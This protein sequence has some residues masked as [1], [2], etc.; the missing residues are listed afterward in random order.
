MNLAKA[1]ESRFLEALE[2]LGTVTITSKEATS[3][4]D[5]LG[6]NYGK[7][8]QMLS[9]LE[10]M[11]KLV[12]L[13]HGLYMTMQ[14]YR[15]LT[16]ILQA[17]DHDLFKVGH[18]T[19]TI[20]KRIKALQTGCPFRLTVY[21]TIPS[22]FPDKLEKVIQGLMRNERKQGEWFAVTAQEID[23]VLDAPLLGPNPWQLDGD[24]RSGFSITPTSWSTDDEGRPHVS[25]N[26]MVPSE[27]EYEVLH[28][29]QGLLQLLKA[30]PGHPK[31]R[32]I[33]R[34]HPVLKK[35]HSSNEELS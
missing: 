30:F 31:H 21:K 25:S 33:W 19:T 22:F 35:F 13:Q 15:R 34:D 28:L 17:E 32:N 10:K 4:G 16:Y 29:A 6:I 9:H 18:T 23:N 26:C 5:T 3:I 1:K 20:D 14:G 11:D 8:R 27:L 2:G 24:M 7:V 12:R